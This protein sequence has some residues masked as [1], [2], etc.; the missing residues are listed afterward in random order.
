MKDGFY[1][2]WGERGEEVCVVGLFRFFRGFFR[3]WSRK[4]IG[5]ELEWCG[6]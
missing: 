3:L 1:V 2:R 4:L 6:D 5:R